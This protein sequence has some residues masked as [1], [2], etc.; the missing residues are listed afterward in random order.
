[1]LFDGFRVM[2]IEID[3]AQISSEGVSMACIDRDG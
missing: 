2:L 1:M 3:R